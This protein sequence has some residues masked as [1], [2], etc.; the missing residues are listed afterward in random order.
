MIWRQVVKSVESSVPERRPHEK[1]RHLEKVNIR[2]VTSDQRAALKTLE[3][4]PDDQI[5]TTDV[6]GM[7]DWLDAR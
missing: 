1:G 7:L 4:L 5:D 2:R 3:E 6:P